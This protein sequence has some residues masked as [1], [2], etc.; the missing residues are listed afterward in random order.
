MFNDLNVIIT[1]FAMDMPSNVDYLEVTVDGGTAWVPSL[2]TIS[3]TCVV[4]Q[5]PAMQRDD[6]SFNDFASGSLMLS[7]KGWI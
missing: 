6:F 7:K 4:Q 2:T 3:V 5:T 1:D